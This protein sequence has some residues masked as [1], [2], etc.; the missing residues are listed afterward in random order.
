MAEDPIENDWV[1]Q[2]SDVAGSGESQ[3]TAAEKGQ[4][5]TSQSRSIWTKRSR[6]EHLELW[7]EQVELQGQ[8]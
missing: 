7:K 4:G 1:R 6:Y 3:Y 8:G 5:G 2:G